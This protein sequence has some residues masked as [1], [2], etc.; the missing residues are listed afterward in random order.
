VRNVSDPDM[1][2]PD[3][4]VFVTEL[5]RRQYVRREVLANE[6]VDASRLFTMSRLRELCVRSARLAGLLEF[7]E[8]SDVRRS[9]M[10]RRAA[11]EAKN[12]FG[13]AGHLGSLSASALADTLETLADTLSPFGDDA[14]LIHAWLLTRKP[15][16]G[17]LQQLGLLYG[18][19]RRLCHAAN[20]LDTRDINAAVLQLLS[21]GR[22]RWPHPLQSLEG[23]LVF[24]S[25]RWLNPFEEKLVA[26][27]KTQLG[28]TRVKVTS[29]LPPAHAEKVQDRLA[30]RIRSDVMVGTGEEWTGWAENLTDA[31][32]VV[33]AN[34][35]IDSRERLDFSRSVGRYG[36]VE[37]LA[38]RIRWE[39]DQRRVTPE[40]IALVV[41]N[42]GDYAD[43]I[44]HVF[45]RF[46]IPC[47]FRRGLP[48]SSF[49]LVKNF[50]SLLSLPLGMERDRFCALL[51]SSALKWN[52]F[53]SDEERRQTAFDIQASGAAPRLSIENITTCLDRCFRSG[54]L[55]TP[56][57]RFPAI[58]SAISESIR[59]LRALGKPATLRAHAR[60]A[61]SVINDF[62]ADQRPLISPL[63][64]V[65]N[66]RALEVT[67]NT[68][69]EIEEA[70]EADSTIRG[71]AELADLLQKSL[72]NATVPPDHMEENGVWVLNPFD[73]AGLRFDVVLIAGLNEGIFPS[74]PRQDSLFSDE[75]RQT[76]RR[77]MAKQGIELPLLALPE[78]TVRGIQES[79]LFLI[80][81]GAARKHL[82]LSYMACDTDG[83]DLIPGE[84]FRSLWNLAGWP[85]ET[86]M[87]LNDYDQWRTATLGPDSHFSR[88]ARKQALT[89]AYQRSPMPGESYLA[90]VPLPLCRAADEAHQRVAQALHD[91]TIQ[92][93]FRILHSPSS[94]PNPTPLSKAICDNLRIEQARELFFNTPAIRRA[95]A[96]PYCGKLADESARKRTAQWRKRHDEFSPTSLEALAQ[97][98]YRFLLAQILRLGAL[99]MQEETPDILDRGRLIHQ[100]LRTIYKSLTGATAD[101]DAA[102]LH[103]F[104]VLCKP[105]AWTSRDQSGSWKLTTD[106]KG[107][108]LASLDF[109]DAV[110]YGDFAEAVADS[111]LQRVEK[112]GEMARLGD[113]GIWATEKPKIRRIARNV[114][115]FD[116][117]F[118][119]EEKRY[120]AL[121]EFRFG[122]Q[123]DGEPP[124]DPAL[125]L[126][127]NN[128]PVAFHGQIDRIDLVFD[129]R[130]ALSKLLVIDYKGP[131][132]GGFSEEAYAEEI[133]QNLNCQLPL[134]AFAAQQYFFGRHND[135]RL[136][137]RTET[138]YHIQTR[139][140]DDMRKQFLNR[141]IH[142]NFV[143]ENKN[144][145][146]ESFLARLTDNLIKLEDSD[147]SVDPLDC[148]YCD[149]RHICRVDVNALE[150]ANK[151]NGRQ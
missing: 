20:V 132:R 6:F 36:E 71:Y 91:P 49:P 121:F 77:S 8:M 143:P 25:I 10:I 15:D 100:I 42:M 28:D 23:S 65:N 63:A 107:L 92:S 55:R 117:Q 14:E 80:T 30:S 11:E 33:D 62:R 111:W 41:R 150:G 75:E 73:A 99:R 134:Y 69:R 79:T 3:L 64:Q 149:F 88:H 46:A 66:R 76:I 97:C 103:P 89:P 110:R 141:R 5:A 133:A 147:F 122:R 135:T 93:E 7:P 94:L 83:R 31:L 22:E 139:H 70:T 125:V 34:L 13:G 129:E 109:A 17:K 24:R 61:L 108:P 106:G 124:D 90:T 43:A 57:A 114:V 32:E 39:I 18:H 37:D 142:L 123:P 104:A 58:L 60:N 85:A 35:A 119:A 45:Q 44:T 137:E 38:R 54:D 113:P 118:A 2:H 48:A 51:Q 95:R 68:L 27:L 112:T 78:S 138:V 145:M 146:M 81:L 127:T 19:Y 126:R 105:R 136:N 120:P 84:F 67:E 47:F 50:L 87:V 9:V 74:L 115:L 116:A 131:G 1:N 52:G 53:A 102:V 26:V 96:E 21:G 128:G 59:R 29:A 101:L 16:G 98:R 86:E 40:K 130:D 140:F 151:E 72:D 144:P 56:P 148:A 82:V 4:I 12:E